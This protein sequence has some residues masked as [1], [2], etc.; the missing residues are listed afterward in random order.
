MFVRWMSLDFPPK[1]MA[2]LPTEG[3]DDPLQPLVRFG[4]STLA[5]V[6]RRPLKFVQ[7]FQKSPLDWIVGLTT[8]LTI[9]P[10]FLVP[11]SVIW[12][13]SLELLLFQQ[14]WI[15][16]HGCRFAILK[17]RI[18]WSK[19]SNLV[20]DRQTEVGD[21]WVRRVGC[22]LR[23]SRLGELPQLFKIIHGEMSSVRQRSHA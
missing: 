11:I 15:G 4:D 9:L 23:K 12:S 5:L 17:L 6:Q 13:G 21:P 22:W 14:P 1:N 10:L 19:Q 7:S 2:K 3:A 8:L 18:I 16:L 20:T